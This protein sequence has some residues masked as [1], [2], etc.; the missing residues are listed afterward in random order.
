MSIMHTP[1]HN[2][3]NQ[4]GSTLIVSMIILI[5]VMLVGVTAMTSSKTGYQLAGNLQ[6]EQS[7]MNSTETAINAAESWLATGTNWSNAGF[8]TYSSGS[9]PQLYPIGALA[10]LTAPANDP[11]TMTWA[12]TNSVQVASNAN[13]RYIIEQ[14]STNNRLT[15][16]SQVVGGRSSSGCNQVNT[17]RITARGA[18]ARGAVKFVQSIYSVLSC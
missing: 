2:R 18:S 12:D 16:S 9:T 7:A 4:S 1:S 10:A 5:L 17:Y 6:F 8:T 11:L 3:H 14:M 15:G 13:Q